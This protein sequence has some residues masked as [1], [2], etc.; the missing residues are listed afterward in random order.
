VPPAADATGSNVV[1]LAADGS[2]VRQPTPAYEPLDR[3]AAGAAESA[4]VEPVAGLSEAKA[5]GTA[6]GAPASGGSRYVAPSFARNDAA[7]DPGEIA[8]ASEWAKAA[9]APPGAAP[10]AVSGGPSASAAPPAA[11]GGSSASA[12]PA[13]AS[14]GASANAALSAASGGSSASA[15]DSAAGAQVVARA[16]PDSTARASLERGDVRL[17]AV[18]PEPA[19]SA[20]PRDEKAAAPSEEKSAPAREDSS[21]GAEELVRK[22]ERAAAAAASAEE[23]ARTA[24]SMLASVTKRQAADAAGK[25]LSGIWELKNAIDTTTYRPYLGLRIGYR[26]RLRHDGN[27]LI[28]TGEKFTESGRTLPAEERTPIVVEGKL[29]GDTVK[30]TFTERYS[31]GS[32]GG[33]MTWQLAP[34]AAQASGRFN[35]SAAKSSGP[36][37]AKRLVKAR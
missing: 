21:E 37:S 29:E 2:L 23:S 19:Q 3:Q 10:P 28:G 27:K 12:A 32:T 17:A 34:G 31:G 18:A 35:S 13:A 15:S 1:A 36:S 33:V 4:P 9:Q 6:E 8:L 20:A 11:S 22:R 25:D 16:D 30:L 24:E 7:D 26:I 5:A 14:V